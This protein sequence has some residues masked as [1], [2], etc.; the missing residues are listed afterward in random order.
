MC[1]LNVGEVKKCARSSREAETAI[2]RIPA[3]ARSEA[4][5]FYRDMRRRGLR[6]ASIR[7]NIAGLRSFMRWYN[8][9]TEW[10]GWEGEEPVRKRCSWW[11]GAVSG[12]A[13]CRCAAYR[14]VGRAMR[15]RAG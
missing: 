2:E 4:L 9:S 8:A 13:G 5:E 1:V 14:S 3:C 15:K 10:N 12:G 6:E 7:S 11:K